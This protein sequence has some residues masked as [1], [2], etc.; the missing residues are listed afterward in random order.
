MEEKSVNIK[1]K[2]S[3]FGFV[4]SNATPNTTPVNE[5]ILSSNQREII[6]INEMLEKLQNFI[7]PVMN[8]KSEGSKAATYNFVRYTSVNFYFLKRLEGVKVGQAS[9]EAAKYLWGY[10]AS[11]YRAMT[12]VQW[13]KEFLREGKPSDHSQGVHSKRK[14]FLNYSDVKAMVLEEIR[15]TKPAERSLVVIKQFIENVVVPSFLGVVGRSV[16]ETTLSRYLYKWGY[17]YRKN[18]KMIRFDG[19][20]REEDV[21]AYRIL[22]CKRMMEYI[23]KMDFYSGKHEEV[24]LE[25]VLEEGE[26]I[27]VFVT[28]NERA[29]YANDGKNDLWLMEGETH[30]RKK[31]PGAS[32]MVSKFQRPCHGTMK[33]QGWTSRTLFKAGDGIEGW[34]TYYLMVKQLEKQAIGLFEALHPN[35]TAVFLFDNSSNHGAYSDDA[36]VASRMTLLNEK[37]WSLDEKYQFRDTTVTLTNDEVLHQTFFYDKQ[38]KS[39]NRKGYPQT[40]SVRYFKGIKRILEERRQWIGHDDIQGNKL[41]LLDCGAPNPE[42]NKICCARHFLS[43]RPDFLEQ[44]SALQEVVE[45]AGHIFELYPKYHCECN[46]IEMYWGAA[47][48]EACLGCDYTVKSLDANLNN[49]LDKAGHL[50]HIRRYFRRAMEYIEAYNKCNDGREVVSA[51]KKFVEKKYL[52]HR[53]SRIPSDLAVLP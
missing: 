52:L 34:W 12:I 45:N 15:K 50:P 39:I 3:D 5:P 40:K 31:G 11:S 37:Q 20:K 23:Q 21:V 32:I 30:I 48:R 49:F 47:K 26:K 19:H 43:T 29:F 16:S 51:V 42:L 7:K 46:W 10:D 13:A 24:V 4:P 41:K 6:Q 8:Q 1:Q 28:Q 14:S 36:L 25:P 33:I 18:K 17:A 53:K 9:A 38:I 2:L 22:W 35:C 27:L 44:R